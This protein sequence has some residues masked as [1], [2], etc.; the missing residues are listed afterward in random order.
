MCGDHPR[1]A[2]GGLYHCAKFGWNRCSSFEYM[3]VFRFR[4]FGLKT[5]IHAPKLRVFRVD[6][7]NGEQ[8]EKFRKKGTS[9][10]ESVSFEPSC[11]KIPRDV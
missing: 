6:P 11:V 1:R 7:L 2:F 10:R 4:A 3:D 9:L 5:P 8:C